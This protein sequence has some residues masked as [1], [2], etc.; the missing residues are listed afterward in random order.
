VTV[1]ATVILKR[2]FVLAA[3]TFEFWFT[4]EWVSWAWSTTEYSAIIAMFIVGFGIVMTF[5]SAGALWVVYLCWFRDWIDTR[6]S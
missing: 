3:I 2:M 1:A 5:L 6:I 4:V